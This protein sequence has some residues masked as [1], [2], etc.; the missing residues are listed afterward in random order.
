[1]KTIIFYIILILIAVIILAK[2]TIS[3]DPFKIQA[4]QKMYALGWLLFFVGM[5]IMIVSTGTSN[6]EK[7]YKEGIDDLIKMTT[8]EKIEKSIK[9]E[10]NVK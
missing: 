1:M 10:T 3:F 6:Y 4:E 2:T 5:V 7:G 8:K 9:E